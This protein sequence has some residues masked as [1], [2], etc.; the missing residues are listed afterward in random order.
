MKILV[1]LVLSFAGMTASVLGLRWTH[2][3]VWFFCFAGAFV[4]FVLSLGDLLKEK[5]KLETLAGVHALA[6]VLFIF[7]VAA[8]IAGI[9]NDPAYSWKRLLFP[10]F[11]MAGSV[12]AAYLFIWIRGQ[13]NRLLRQFMAYFV[14]WLR[15]SFL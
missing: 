12:Y 15:Q 6:I 1:F 3:D 13:L 9:L 10:P 14:T 11:V 5:W 7:G 2:D 4:I 8:D